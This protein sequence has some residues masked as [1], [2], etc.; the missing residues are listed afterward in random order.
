[1]RSWCGSRKIPRGC[2]SWSCGWWRPS[3]PRATARA[4][5][6]LGTPESDESQNGGC[7]NLQ[8]SIPQLGCGMA[9][10]DLRSDTVTEPSDEMRGA[11]ARAKV[12][13]DVL[14]EEPAGQEVGTLAPAT[15]GK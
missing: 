15:L 7:V 14:R 6:H 3:R 4:P 13:D 2:G 5:P 12:R 10:I 8:S 11:I 1:M 9:V